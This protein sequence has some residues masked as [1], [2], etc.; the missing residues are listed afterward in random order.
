VQ[1]E[2]QRLE[3]EAT[4]REQAW[5]HRR[6]S[7]CGNTPRRTRRN[8]AACPK[9]NSDIR[10]AAQ[11]QSNVSGWKPRPHAAS[12]PGCNRRRSAC[13]NTPRR[14]RRNSAACPK[15]NSDIRRKRLSGIECQ[16]LEAE[17]HTPRAGLAAT[18][19]GA[20]PGTRRGARGATA[21]PVRTPA[22]AFGPAVRNGS[23]AI[24]MS[25]AG[26]R[27]TRREQDWLQQTAEREREHAAST[28]GATA[29]LSE[30][31]QRHSEQ[32]AEAAQWQSECQ[33]LEAEATRR[34]RTGCPDCGVRA[35]HAAAYRGATALPVNSNS[36]FGTAGGAKQWQSECQ[37]WK[38]KSH[39]ASRT[40]CK[41]TASASGKHAARTRRTALP[42][43]TRTGHSEQR[44][45]TAQWQ[46]ECQRLEAGHAREQ[47]WLQQTAEREREQAAALSE[48][49]QRHRTAGGSGAVAIE[50]GQRLEAEASRASMTGCDRTAER[51]RDTPQRMRHT[52]LPGRT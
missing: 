42:S 26:S 30:L 28:R 9:S 6:R 18:D 4:R 51:E 21:L 24:G 16:R 23:V 37:R 22:A 36:D 19:R 45:E 17:A 44:A 5:L 40:G 50:K 14:T 1:S 15:S 2:C 12:R 8:S 10:E 3:A 11:W 52:A 13:G 49:Q 35:E 38:P 34:G 31:R 33:R 47:D 29:R 41:Q 27:A 43:E 20:R 7:A 39:G 25:A 46:S 32:Q 48:F